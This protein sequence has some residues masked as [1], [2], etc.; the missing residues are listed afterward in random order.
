MFLGSTPLNLDA[1]GRVAVPAKHRD[2]LAPD[3][4]QLV[5]TAHPHGC[6]LVYPFVAWQPIYESLVKIPSLDPRAA[7]FK[8]L[9]IGHAQ[10]EQ[11]DSA[12]RVLL[13]AALREWA[14]L[15]KQVVMVGQGTYCELWSDERWKGQQGGMT[16]LDLNACPGAFENLVL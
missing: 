16:E 11:V 4:A 2:G 10:V 6:L 14:A 5:I 15:D 9:L 8:R 13:G 12:G 7:L 3:G 1:K